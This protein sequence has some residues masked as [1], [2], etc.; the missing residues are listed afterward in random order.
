[1]ATGISDRDVTK[2]LVT[3]DETLVDSGDMES[4]ESI[5]G[6]MPSVRG[7]TFTGMTNVGGLLGVSLMD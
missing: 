1:L 5:E 6:R 2:S 3:G 7:H 4:E